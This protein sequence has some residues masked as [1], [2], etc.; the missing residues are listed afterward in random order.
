MTSN[1]FFKRLESMLLHYLRRYAL[2]FDAFEAK[3][4]FVLFAC[5]SSTSYCQ[6]EV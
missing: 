6:H 1:I 3:S 2:E 4:L 5:L